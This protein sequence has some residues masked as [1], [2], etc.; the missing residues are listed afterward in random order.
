[1]TTPKIGTVFL[2]EDN[3]EGESLGRQNMEVILKWI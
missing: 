3:L 2:W 1:M